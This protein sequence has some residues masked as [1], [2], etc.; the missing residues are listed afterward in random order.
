MSPKACSNDF[1]NIA[2]IDF[3]LISRPT[4]NIKI[5]NGNPE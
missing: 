3:E 1:L 5:L 2:S 4:Q